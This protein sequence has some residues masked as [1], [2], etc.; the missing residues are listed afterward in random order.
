MQAYDTNNQDFEIQQIMA[1]LF[2]CELSEHKSNSYPAILEKFEQLEMDAMY[3]LFALV[4]EQLPKRAKLFFAGENFMGKKQVIEEVM[5]HLF[6][7]K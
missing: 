6:K 7:N 5:Y 4:Q 1:Y 2:G 3:Q